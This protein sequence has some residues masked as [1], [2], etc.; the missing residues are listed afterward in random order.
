[1]ELNFII[2][3]FKFINWNP[4]WKKQIRVSLKE[5]FRSETTKRDDRLLMRFNL[6]LIINWCCSYIAKLRFYVWWWWW[7]SC[8]ERETLYPESDAKYRILSP[9]SISNHTSATPLHKIL[10]SSNIYKYIYIIY[11][12]TTIFIWLYIL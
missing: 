4:C 9:L 10:L 7:T 6:D 8:H 11:Q 1:M 2:R 12:S 5:N 3:F